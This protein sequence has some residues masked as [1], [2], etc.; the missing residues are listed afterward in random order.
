[1]WREGVVFAVVLVPIILVVV[2][3]AV[4]ARVTSR[5]LV[6]LPFVGGGV[7][8]AVVSR[9]NRRLRARLEAAGGRLCTECGYSLA[10]LAERG[11]C[12]ECGV[13]YDMEQVRAAWAAWK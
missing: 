2:L 9:R 3:W 7:H 13:A 12:P 6:A 1:M 10:G 4:P 5:W 11:T 8:L